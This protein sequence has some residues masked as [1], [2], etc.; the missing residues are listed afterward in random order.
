VFVS[1][2]VGA[3]AAQ[4]APT[5]NQ[6]PSFR[7]Q[8]NLVLVPTLVKNKKGEIVF[9]LHA[10]DFIIEDDGVEQALRLDETL[11]PAPLS[12]VVAVQVGRSA[13]AELQRIRTL[14]AMLDLVLGE[15]GNRAALVTFDSR[16]RLVRS[17]TTNDEI[18][19]AD[20]KQLRSGDNGAA[21]LDAIGYSVTLLKREP[22]ER[23]RIL[24]LV[25]ETRDHGSHVISSEAA[26][27]AIAQSNTLVYSLAF[28]P[29]ASDVLDTMRGNTGKQVEPPQPDERTPEEIQSGRVLAD[30][31][32]RGSIR[33]EPLVS[34]AVQA[35][36][37]NAPKTIVEMTGGEYELFT[38]HKGFEARMA[39]FANHFHNRYLLSFEPKDPHPGLHEVRVRLRQ[40]WEGTILARRRYWFGAP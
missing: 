17:F 18:F 39:E 40:G 24:L 14:G 25:S 38:S 15:A 4:E 27:H 29:A 21:I 37:K 3:V 5:D 34:L 6:Q 7:T 30:G 9:G 33:L 23:Q 12:L 1:V 22:E 31:S 13:A 28:S 19:A 10:G 26:V 2:L 35:M 20:L 16:V 32:P 8:S 36:R 11:E